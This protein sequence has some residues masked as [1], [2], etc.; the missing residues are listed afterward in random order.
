[1]HLREAI[2]RVI[3]VLLIPGSW[4]GVLIVGNIDC[5]LL[6]ISVV[7]R[8]AVVIHNLATVRGG[9]VSG[10]VRHHRHQ[11]SPRVVVKLVV[12]RR[13]SAE[14]FLRQ[15]AGSIVSV[16]SRNRGVSAR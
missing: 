13:R 16:R 12:N 4:T 6:E 9:V 5:L 11:L 1:M 15:M 3:A 10:S 7:V 8:R 2:Q 14:L